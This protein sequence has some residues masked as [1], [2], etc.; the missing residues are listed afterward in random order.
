M[1]LAPGF[2]PRDKKL[3]NSVVGDLISRN[4][5]FFYKIIAP[6]RVQHEVAGVRVDAGDRPRVVY[7][8][9]VDYGLVRRAAGIAEQNFIRPPCRSLAVPASGAPP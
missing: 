1:Q 8:A 6:L 5:G 3:Q 9:G 4:P 2:I 7:L